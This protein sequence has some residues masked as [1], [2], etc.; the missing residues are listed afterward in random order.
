[1]PR[2]NRTT[3]S[4]SRSA[5]LDEYFRGLANRPLLTAEEELA[6]AQEIVRATAGLSELKRSGAEAATLL[7][8]R[9]HVR[10]IKQQMVE[11]NLRLVVSIAKRF[12]NRGTPLADLVQ[13]GN[14]GLMAAVDRFDP[15]YGTR[16]STYASWWIHEGIRRS[17]QNTARA[18][19]IPVHLNDLQSRI[20][21]AAAAFTA[22]FGREP[23]PEEIAAT[24]GLRIAQVARAL[25]ARM[26]EPR[27]LD[28]LVDSDHPI[29]FV[30]T[31]LDRNR[32]SP[33]D[34]V[35]ARERALEAL[36][37]LDTLPPREAE[38]LRERFV[39]G[40]TLADIG[41][42]F[43]LSRERVR[44]IEAAALDRM[45]SQTVIGDPPHGAAERRV[46]A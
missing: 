28:Q 36:R 24:T 38:I 14:L 1:V 18:I 12:A 42:G 44:Q 8:A 11:A 23:T 15:A 27:S 13:E 34:E 26:V 2:R 19:R 6:L 3:E 5:S 22:E 31:L 10:R 4:S 21:S 17:L 46:R 35:D 16:F 45:R 32:P 9:E 37:L 30:D 29:T 25:A 40:R 43:G 41:H 7:Q 20:G 33:F 39:E